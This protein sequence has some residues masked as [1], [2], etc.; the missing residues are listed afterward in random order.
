MNNFKLK[1]IEFLKTNI[2]NGRVVSGQKEYLT[3]CP[4]CMDS[5]NPKSAH[6]YISIPQNENDIALYDCKKCNAHGIFNQKILREFEIYDTEMISEIIK[7]NKKILSNPNNKINTFTGIYQLNNNYITINELSDIK[8]KYINHRL[9]LNLAYQDLLDNKI[10]LNLY[11]LLASNNITTLTRAQNIADQLNESFI[12]FISFDN[13]YINM[14]NLRSKGQVYKSIDK[15]YVNYNIFNKV[16]NSKRYYI[17]PTEINTLSIDPIQIHIAEGPFDI[18][19]VFYNVMNG[20]KQNKI[21]SSIGGKSYINMIK[22]FL[23]EL[24]LI[25][26][27]FHIYIDNDIEDRDIYYMANILSGLNLD[28]YFHRNIYPNEKDY[29]VPKDRIKDYSWQITRRIL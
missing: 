7:R 26:V 28:I 23:Q 1:F 11:D 9:G 21:Y 22:F 14:R 5:K 6:F 20:D 27:E 12:G 25:N 24:G 2:P 15:R 8:L 13:A 3:R 16:D 29:G 19:G 17:I 18:L 4:L 10:I